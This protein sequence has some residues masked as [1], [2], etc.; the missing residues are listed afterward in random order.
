M[1]NS[2]CSNKPHAVFYLAP[3]SLRACWK[4]PPGNLTD[5]EVRFT[6]HTMAAYNGSTDSNVE[7]LMKMQVSLLPSEMLILRDCGGPG[8]LH[9]AAQRLGDSDANS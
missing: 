7:E 9:Y 2:C 3:G 6:E 1:E 8:D 4:V 5:T